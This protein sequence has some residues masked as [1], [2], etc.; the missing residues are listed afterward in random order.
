[1]ADVTP[2]RLAWKR[3]CRSAGFSLAVR[4]QAALCLLIAATFAVAA[5]DASAI[6]ERRVKAALLYR[7]LN[8]VEWQEPLQPAANA[9]FTIAVVGA[10]PL[11][12][13]LTEFAAGRAVQS[14]PLAV[15]TLRATE[16]VREA[17]VVFVGR[18]ETSN[19]AAIARGAPNALIVTESDDGLAQGAVINFRL[20]D[21]QVRFDVALDAAKRRGLRLSARLLSVAYSI[22][23]AAS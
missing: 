14:H 9:P 20:V 6:L 16:P 23:G 18:G 22:Q 15:R 8:Y 13:E 3:P 17:H 4:V 21:G 10:D 19:L 2:S 1:M 11:A 5:D 12:A 7:F